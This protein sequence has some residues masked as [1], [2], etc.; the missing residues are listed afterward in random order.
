[1]KKYVNLKHDDEKKSFVVAAGSYAKQWK[2]INLDYLQK[3]SPNN[4]QFFSKMMI[5]FRSES[6][7]SLEKIKM[8]YT[9]KDFCMV[10]KTAHAMKPTGSYIGVDTLTSLVGSLE[11]AAASGSHPIIDNL[12]GEIEDLVVGINLEIDEFLKAA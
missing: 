12:I 1:M 8:H 2:Y 3:I 10:E 7:A 5:V 11:N 4:S 9:N 6:V